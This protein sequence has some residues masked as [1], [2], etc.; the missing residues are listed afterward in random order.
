MSSNGNAHQRPTPRGLKLNKRFISTHDG[1]RFYAVNT[2]AVRDIAQPDEEFGSFA[3]REDFPTLIPRG[4]VWLAEQTI[5]QEGLF[6]I[7]NAVTQLK[8]RARGVPDDQAYTEGIHVERMLRERLNRLRFRGGR[9]QKRVPRQVYVGRYATLPDKRGTVE[10]WIVDGNVVRSLYKTD[11]TEGGH[12][13]VYPWVPRDEIW[14]E[15]SLDRREL[16]YIVAHEY[17]ER[18]LMRDIKLDYDTAHE[19]CSRVEFKL[20]KNQRLKRFLAPGRRKI[21]KRDLPKLA[22]DEFFHYVVNHFVKTREPDGTE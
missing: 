6:F 21:H 16:P 7:A 4:E 11:Y 2:Y 1:H 3:T 18:R 22:S 14:I 8:E 19:I 9:P 13:Y 5:D 17:L 10:V 20:R 12:G 15:Q